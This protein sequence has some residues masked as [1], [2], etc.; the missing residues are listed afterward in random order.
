MAES[1]REGAGGFVVT[2]QPVFD[3]RL[4][5]WG[6]AVAFVL[7]PEE[8]PLF[9]DELTASFLL[10]A[11]MPHRGPLHDVQTIISLSAAAILDGIPNILSPQGMFLEVEEDAGNDPNIPKALAQS[12]RAGFGIAVSGFFNRSSCR[13]LNSLA[14]V[15]ILDAN[16]P[17][18]GGGET[19]LPELILSARQFAAK[20][21]VRGLTNWQELLQARAANADMFQG[22]FFNRMNLALSGKSVTATQLSRLRILECLDKPDA[23]FKALARLVEAD[24]ALTYRL[25]VFLN[26]PHFG[27]GRKVR[28]IEQAIVLA[29]WKP[30][31]NWL[32]IVLITDLS[33]SPRHQ[34]LC[35]YSAQRSDFLQ[36]VARA[37]GLERLVPALSLLGL[38]SYLE[39]ILEIP[40]DHALANVP[41]EDDLRLALCGKRSP[42]SPWLALVQAME[43]CDWSHA[44]RLGKSARLGMADLARCYHESFAQADTLFRVLDAPPVPPA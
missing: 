16:S 22:F 31:K 40:M 6:S 11:Y 44:E 10:E 26:S 25:L 34:E 5:P 20:V 1:G 19:A 28:S 29:G 21:Q 43:R 3:R 15:L 30:L 38:L 36:R 23:D 2:R 14:D 24:A 32:K 42:L 8:G 33:P 41:V 17:H 9:S 13:A 4:Q 39:P 18:A 35:Y 37:A 12:K 27:F 7:S